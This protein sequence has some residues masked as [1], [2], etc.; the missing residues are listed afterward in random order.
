MKWLKIL[1]ETILKDY[2]KEELYNYFKE[3]FDVEPAIIV[4]GHAIRKI[5]YDK[6]NLPEVLRCLL[7]D[8]VE[9]SI[10]KCI[11][12]LELCK[13]I[14]TETHDWVVDNISFKED[15]VCILLVKREEMYTAKINVLLVL[16]G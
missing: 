11:I 8:R 16:K 12:Y 6:D 4:K 14:N 10:K 7:F 2:E 5:I 9:E 13:A 3:E 15:K 1:E